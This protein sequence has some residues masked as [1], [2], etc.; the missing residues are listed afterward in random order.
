MHENVFIDF[1]DHWTVKEMIAFR[2]E[3]YNADIIIIN[4]IFIIKYLAK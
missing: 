2:L 1:T 4:I 3:L